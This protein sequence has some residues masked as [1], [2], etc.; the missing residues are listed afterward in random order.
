MLSCGIVGLPMTGKTTFFRLLT[1]VSQGGRGEAP[2]KGVAKIPDQRVVFLSGVYHPKKITYAQMEFADVPGFAPGTGQGGRFLAEAREVDALVQVLRAFSLGG[3]EPDPLAD[4]EAIHL[5]LVLADLEF[6]EKRLE[7]ARGNKKAKPGETALLECCRSALEDGQTI[8]SLGL[9]SEE[10]KELAGYSLLTEKP[11]LVVA[12]VGEEGFRRGDYPGREQLR[13]RTT[14]AR[15]PFVETCAQ[16]EEEIQELPMEEREEF[17][18]D[19]G[20]AESGIERVARSVYAHLGLIS[21]L[22]AGEDEVR[23]WTIKSRTTAKEAAGKIHSD[24][25]RGFIRAEVVAFDDFAATGSLAGARDKGTL[26]LE[27]KEYS[28][29]DGDIINFRFNVAK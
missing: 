17:L 25:E 23:A 4:L 1:G 27:G 11:Y 18:R 24:I 26:R 15:L 20:V 8:R 16:L 12:N 7:R 14:E 22:T 28:V 19:L 3:D 10:E 9:S 29:Q 5:E 6:L 21:F 13:Q 2:G